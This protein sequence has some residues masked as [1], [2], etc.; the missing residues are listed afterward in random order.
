MKFTFKKYIDCNGDVQYYQSPVFVDEMNEWEEDGYYNHYDGYQ[1][2]VQEFL[3]KDVGTRVILNNNKVFTTHYSDNNGVK[4]K[5]EAIITNDFA[6][7]SFYEKDKKKVGAK[8]KKEM[9]AGAITGVLESVKL[10]LMKRKDIQRLFFITVD[11][12]LERFTDT[13]IKWAIKKKKI[14]G[15][16]QT[17]TEKDIHGRKCY[18]LTR[19]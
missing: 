2:I 17:G 1:R 13:F 6:T 18:W 3:D 19:N 15:I 7:I 5:F 12:D 10:L 8:K 11:K 14:K 9:N 16:K 4:W